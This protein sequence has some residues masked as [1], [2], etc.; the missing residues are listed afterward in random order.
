MFDP[1]KVMIQLKMLSFRMK[2]L[3]YPDHLL[4]LVRLSA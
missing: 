3:T 4:K 2:P 1:A